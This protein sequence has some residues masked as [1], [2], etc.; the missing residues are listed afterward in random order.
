MRGKMAAAA[1]DTAAPIAAS[2]APIDLA[3]RGRESAAES[4]TA[5][6]AAIVDLVRATIC[7]A[8]VAPQ[9]R[10]AL[11]DLPDLDLCCAADARA[12]E[13]APDRSALTIEERLALTQRL[14]GLASIRARRLTDIERRA[15]D[16]AAADVHRL[17]DLNR[18]NGAA[19]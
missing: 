19:A 18:S 14:A 7:T 9:L 17:L 3:Q 6:I 12:R 13:S 16:A 8:D 1:D 15:V 4:Q 11:L 10:A 2:T 5:M